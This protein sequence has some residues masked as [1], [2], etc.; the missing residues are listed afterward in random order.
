[1]KDYQDFLNI[2]QK[3]G[4]KKHSI[5]H[6]LGSR[7]AWK[8]VRKN[9]WTALNGN[10]C[11]STLYAAII[12]D[13]NEMLVERLLE[14]HPVDF[15]YQMGTLQLISFDPVIRNKNGKITNNYIVDWKKTLKCW[16]EDGEMRE[17]KV[18]VKRIQKKIVRIQYSKEKA[19]FKFRKYYNFRL[20]R[21]LVKLLGKRVANTKMNTLIC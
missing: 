9:R 3:R 13:I 18:L 12:N 5:G 8:W 4:S 21:S 1:M 10:T 2:L 15:P 11:S 17:K 16:Y 7:D 20:N 14:G 6:C 19:K